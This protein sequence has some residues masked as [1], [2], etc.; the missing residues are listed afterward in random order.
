ME[1]A[2][3]PDCHIILRG[4]TAPNYDA[5]SVAAAA[6]ALKGAGVNERL[7]IDCSHA[8]SRKDHRLQT[9]V[10]ADIAVQLTTGE[11]RIMG[12]MIESH[13][14]AGRQD[15][16][17]GKPLEYGKSITDACIGWD[18]SLGVLQTLSDAVKARRRR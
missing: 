8:N 17:A 5:A 15:Q 6:K 13:L 14:K 18:D 9:E 3:N 12:V 2:G 10:C 1:T 4:G 16:V 7:M 11:E